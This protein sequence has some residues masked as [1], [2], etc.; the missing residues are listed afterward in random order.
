MKN[1]FL[2]LTL[3]LSLIACD[4]LEKADKAMKSVGNMDRKM[5]TMNDNMKGMAYDLRL[6]VSL[7]NYMD[8]QNYDL[9]DPIAFKLAPWAKTVADNV[10]IKDLVELARAE[11]LAIDS[12]K[13]QK[14]VD[15]QGQNIPYTV[16][17]KARLNNQKRVIV[18]FLEQIAGL[19][20]ES[21][22]ALLIK[23]AQEGAYA[24]TA[25]KLLMLRYEFIVDFQ[26]G[27]VKM[28]ES[29]TNIAMAQSAFDE[30]NKA[31]FLARIDVNHE[32][33][34]K[35]SGLKRLTD[36]DDE[37]DP[38]YDWQINSEDL[39][40]SWSVLLNRLDSDIQPAPGGETKAG[41]GLTAV[42]R[43][44]QNVNAAQRIQ[45]LKAQIQ[46]KLDYWNKAAN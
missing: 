14:A 9:V 5:D 19:L 37:K 3:S 22:T 20:P 44:N 33:A 26:F 25:K 40:S 41:L 17:E 11:F 23:E 12:G 16:Q 29:F 36:S 15:D 43:H 1:I 27:V 30:L 8:Q 35:T 4:K 34:F 38:N 18:N 45:G 7:Q 31:D 28:E 24:P 32:L 21:T 39:K 6:G 13:V 46:A 42:Q 10:K 2:L